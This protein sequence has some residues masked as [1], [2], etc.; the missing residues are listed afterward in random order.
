LGY[1]CNGT[2]DK[3]KSSCT[4]FSCTLIDSF[5]QGYSPLK[6]LVFYLYVNTEGG[7]RYDH[8]TS[9]ITFSYQTRI[10]YCVCS[11]F[12]ASSYIFVLCSWGWGMRT[13]W[14]D[15]FL[16]LNP[17][18]A[19]SHDLKMSLRW[20]DFSLLS[21]YLYLV[22]DQ[23]IPFWKLDIFQKLILSA[24]CIILKYCTLHFT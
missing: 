22:L 24:V 8:S 12:P 1:K 7:S 21:M 15:V 20:W 23:N 14:A 4:I 10:L 5:R 9:N 3:E 16:G 6:V 19:W 11:V 13:I 17:R 18:V 2:R